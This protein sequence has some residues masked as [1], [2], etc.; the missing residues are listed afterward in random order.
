MA[1]LRYCYLF[2]SM[3]TEEI[4]VTVELYRRCGDMED[5]FMC[6]ASLRELEEA[7]NKDFKRQK[8]DKINLKKDKIN[9]ILNDLEEKE[10]ITIIKKAKGRQ[11]NLIRINIKDIITKKYNYQKKADN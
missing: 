5:I 7:I 3:S 2:D 6:E 1:G 11:K 4:A 8:L 9:K 10:Y